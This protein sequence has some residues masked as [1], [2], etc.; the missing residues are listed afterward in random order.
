MGGDFSA[1]FPDGVIE[2]PYDIVLAL[3]VALVVLSWFENLPRNEQ[4]PRH[5]WWS[6]ELIDEWFKSVREERE[7]RS[8]S[9][10]RRSSYDEAQDVPMSENE[11][12]AQLRP[13]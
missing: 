11:L 3:N 4:P 12:A 2:A 5:I 7:S 8:G 10:K 9:K 6:D 1:F 13:R